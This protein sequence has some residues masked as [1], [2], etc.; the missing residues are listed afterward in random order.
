MFF[1]FLKL[2]PVFIQIDIKELLVNFRYIKCLFFLPVLY[3]FSF[4]IPLKNKK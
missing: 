1:L 2:Y 3:L 4:I